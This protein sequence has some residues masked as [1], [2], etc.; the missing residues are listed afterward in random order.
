MFRVLFL[1][2]ILVAFASLRQDLLSQNPRRLRGSASRSSLK[3]SASPRLCVRIFSL[4]IL[5]V[6]AALRQ[7]LLSQILR[8]SA[9][10]RQDLLSQNSLASPR[11]CVKIFSLKILGVSAALR[12]DLLSQILGVS[13]AL[14]QTWFGSASGGNGATSDDSV[15]FSPLALAR[16]RGFVRQLSIRRAPPYRIEQAGAIAP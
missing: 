11:L 13:A 9:A 16:G 15:L 2:Q 1:S 10:L 6:S 5:G 12:Q 3:S 7:D 8:V 4:K 14:R